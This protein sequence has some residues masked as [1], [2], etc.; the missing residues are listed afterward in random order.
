[1]HSIVCPSHCMISLCPTVHV[2]KI[3]LIL[4]IFFL[5]RY[6]L[7]E[8]EFVFNL[9]ECFLW[10]LTKNFKLDIWEA[11][12][13]MLIFF[14]RN[15]FYSFHWITW[16]MKWIN[17]EF[18]ATRVRCCEMFIRYTGKTSFASVTKHVIHMRHS[19]KMR[20]LLHLPTSRKE[21]ML[22]KGEPPSAIIIID[23]CIV[24]HSFK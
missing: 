12:L 1:M 21:N 4:A 11:T 24:V 22:V 19:G 3:R 9:H 16:A 2:L 23:I 18:D 8:F 7:Q 14:F 17:A 13:N 6:H 10:P 20:K 5:A 15:L